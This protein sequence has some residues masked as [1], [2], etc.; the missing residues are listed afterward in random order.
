MRGKGGEERG[1]EGR[2]DGG[3]GRRQMVISPQCLQN[4]CCERYC[5]ADPLH[6]PMLSSVAL[7]ILLTSS[8]ASVLSRSSDAFVAYAG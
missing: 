7:P 6:D 3:G 8:D 5:S 1:G 2:W 4:A